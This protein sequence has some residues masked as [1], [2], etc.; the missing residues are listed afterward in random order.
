MNKQTQFRG[1]AHNAH[2]NDKK[3]LPVYETGV[4]RLIGWQ[5]DAFKR[6]KN[7]PFALVSAFCGS[8][9]SVLQIAL[10]IHDVVRS[11]WTRKQLIIVPQQHISQGFTRDGV[12]EYIS[13]MIG[14]KQYDWVIGNNDFCAADQ[15]GVIEGLKK[16]LLTPAERLGA[17]HK[18]DEIVMG[19][20]AVA[21][22][23]ALGLAWESLTEKEKGD[24]V[25]N[26]TLR[27]DE[28][29]HISCVF[30]IHEDGLTATEQ[31]AI[32]EESTNLGGICRYMIN[33]GKRSRI[34]LTTATFFRGDKKHILSSSVQKKFATYFLDWIKHWQTLGIR[35]FEFGYEEYDQDPISCIIDAIRVE[36]NQKHMIVIP[37][38]G[39][40]W[41]A[42]RSTEL[43][44]LLKEIY[45]LYPEARVLDLVTKET[46]DRN[47]ALL[48]MEPKKASDGESKYDV[49]ITCMLGR[50]GTDWCPCSR[51]HN[52]ACEASVTLAVQTI[53]RI[54]R[55]FDGKST[56]RA[57]YYVKRF[58]VIQIGLS[59]RELFSERT[60][61]LLVCI[62]LDEL[63]HP[64]EIVRF[65]ESEK[66]SGPSG[67]HVKLAEIFSNHYQAVKDRLIDELGDLQL[68][69]STLN[70]SVR[71]VKLHAGIDSIVEGIVNDYKK[72]V[73][74]HRAGVMNQLRLMA[75]R[76]WSPDFRDLG[77]DVSILRR[78][79]FDKIVEEYC[80]S[81]KSI[82]F[83]KMSSKDWELVRS[84][85]KGS[86]IWETT[87][88]RAING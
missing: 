7:E 6:L 65:S 45:K 62:Q 39:A 38:T 41:R 10:S 44:R 55:R 52:A 49:V 61:S 53:G 1:R 31:V 30:D 29:H 79:G 69:T 84:I 37:A 32:E 35:D 67:E 77:F 56:V 75:V 22:H 46:Q 88:Q 42:H 81:G 47:K 50:E 25:R 3:Y 21:S 4:K 27:V 72:R 43:A 76:M 2:W 80:T 28:A 57:Q 15:K 11:D 78:K 17:L 60:N 51:L 74:R 23:Q 83:G 59:K 12:L 64:L 82:F 19:V 86:G 14:S 24:A 48:L 54:F 13:L 8:G 71:L 87:Y 16:W 9:K 18:H 34:H 5:L 58:P 68:E 73:G 26:L 85:I 66:A 63:C 40:K 33:H 20:I 36:P 70:P